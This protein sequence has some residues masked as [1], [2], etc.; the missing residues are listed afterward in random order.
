MIYPSCSLSLKVC[1][2]TSFDKL[3]ILDVSYSRV[4]FWVKAAPRKFIPSQK[5]ISPRKVDSF[6]S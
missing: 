1:L 5:G 2:P 4:Y 6:E 3:L